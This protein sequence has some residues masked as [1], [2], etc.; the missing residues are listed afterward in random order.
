[1]NNEEIKAKLTEFLDYLSKEKHVNIY[2]YVPVDY[3][4]GDVNWYEKKMDDADRDN[5]ITLFMNGETLRNEYDKLIKSW[6]DE[7]N[8]D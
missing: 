5:L 7:A 4:D 6:S 8:E 2:I 1:M 3:G